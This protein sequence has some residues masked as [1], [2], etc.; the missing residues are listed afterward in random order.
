[1]NRSFASTAILAT[2]VAL[3]GVSTPRIVRAQTGSPPP[4]VTAE[5]PPAAA[6]PAAPAQPA[7]PAAAGRTSETTSAPPVTAEAPGSEPAEPDATDTPEAAPESPPAEPTEWML[8]DRDAYES[9]TLS[10]G[11]GLLRTQHAESTAPG[12]FRLSLVGE[13]FSANFL[14]TNKFPCPVGGGAP[15]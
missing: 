15:V 13:W 12:Q 9:N 8:R 7:P 6:P 14:C 10:G 1:M 4:P 3:W 11:L 2:A 5:P